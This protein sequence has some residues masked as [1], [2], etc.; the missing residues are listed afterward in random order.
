MHHVALHRQVTRCQCDIPEPPVGPGWL[1]HVQAVDLV[2]A[3]SNR[4]ELLRPL[5]DVL[6]PS[7]VLKPNRKQRMRGQGI[8]S[9]AV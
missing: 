3:Y 8:D 7:S 4:P 2:A 9:E 5:A 1:G 6:R